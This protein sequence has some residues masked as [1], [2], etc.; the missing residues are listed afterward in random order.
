MQAYAK[1]AKDKQMEADAFELRKR[2][3]HRLGEIMD[4]QKEI[5]GTAQGKRTDLGFQ[6][7][8]AGLVLG[9]PGPFSLIYADLGAPRR[10]CCSTST[11][12]RRTAS[13]C[14]SMLQAGPGRNRLEAS[15]FPVFFRWLAALDQEQEPERSDL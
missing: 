9:N 2:A 4:E 12:T 1:Q 5:H 10:A 15:R 3:E 13:S 11:W 7:T 6:K 8:Q 14:S